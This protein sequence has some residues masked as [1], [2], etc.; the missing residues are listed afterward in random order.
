M[1]KLTSAVTTESVHRRFVS[2][3]AV[4]AVLFVS[5]CQD[6][7]EAGGGAAERTGSPSSPRAPGTARLQV[8]P[9]D[10][11]TRVPPAQGVKVTARGARIGA[12]TVTDSDGMKVEGEFTADHSGWV[13]RDALDFDTRYTVIAT[14]TGRNGEQTTTRST[15]TTATP[16]ARLHTAILPLDGET[17]GVGIPIQVVFSAPVAD[18]AAAERSL[19]VV[20]TPTV[21]GAWHW[22]SDKKVRYRPQTYWP[23][24]TKVTLQVRL[25]RVDFGNG[26]YGDERRDV[27]FKIGRSMISVVD[28]KRLRMS[29]FRDGKVIRTMP[30]TMGKKGWETR[31]GIKVVLEKYALKVMDGATVGI[32]RS[33]PEY[34][35][36][37]VP[38]AVRMTWSGEFV[39][40]AP[41]SVAAQGTT[42][43]SHGCVGMSVDNAKWYFGQTIRGDVIKVVGSPTSRTMELDNGFGDWNLAW[44]AWR[45][46]SALR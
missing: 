36:L 28:G 8:T 13:A 21:S 40:G 14:A 17:V 24:G 22:I 33:S 19:A 32:P 39:H 38:W 35:R 16:R 42:R 18:R 31:N 1:R 37:D 27:S 23:S 26:V 12:V 44:D 25:R 10:G 41:W 4:I 9:A 46:G 34:Y 30:V 20:S 43:V 15:F 11:A 5:G 45:A 6:E 3:I 2:L 29:V 7:T